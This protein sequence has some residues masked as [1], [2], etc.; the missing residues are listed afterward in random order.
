MNYRQTAESFRREHGL[1]F[2]FS[3]EMPAGYET[4]FGTY[5]PETETLHFN[6]ALQGDPVEA[7]FTL[8]H[9]LRHALQYQKPDAFSP[10]VRESLPYVILYDGTAYK[11]VSGSFRSCRLDLP[12]ETLLNAYLSLPYELDANRYALER[13]RALFP[14]EPDRVESLRA[15]WM[16]REKLTPAQL[17]PLFRRIDSLISEE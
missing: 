8:F 13:V 14:G 11:L 7:A 9:E 5:D 6:E 17:A 16:P 10:D 1:T 12:E 15:R 2:R 3:H 4:A